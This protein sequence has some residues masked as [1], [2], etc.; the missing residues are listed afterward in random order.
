MQN[1]LFA[2]QKAHNGA[3]NDIKIGKK[4]LCYTVGEDQNVRV[5][6]LN[7]LT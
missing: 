5:W 6:D 3:V 4:N 2:S 7:N 1:K